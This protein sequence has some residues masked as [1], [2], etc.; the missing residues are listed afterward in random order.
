MPSTAMSN[1]MTF[2][3]V[4]VSLSE[5]AAQRLKRTREWLARSNADVL[6]VSAPENVLYVSGYESMPAM[7]SRSHPFAVI[8]TADRLML[9]APSA[10]FA[11]AIDSGLS[12]DDVV[13]FGRFFFSG[14]TRS[15]TLDVTHAGFDAALKDALGRLRGTK[16]LVDWHA[17]SD[18]A[19]AVVEAWSAG[20]ED[21]GQWML[22]LRAEKLPIEHTLLKHVA[23][24]TERALDAGI[25]AAAV[26]V[27]DKEVSNVVAAAMSAAGG[28][29]RNVTVAGGSASAL[30]DV[31][32]AE[33][34]LQ[35]GDLLRF[36]IGCSYYGY[37]SDIAR[38]AVMG[39]P[40]GLQ[41]SRYDALLAGLETAFEMARTGAV[42]R[43]VFDA[44]V[45]TVE[46][47]GLS[48]YRRQH[49]GHAIGLSVYEWPVITP[50]STAVLRENATFCLETP[51][52]EP[53]WGGMMVEDTGF[54]TREGFK[55]FTTLDR[56]LRVIGA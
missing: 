40:T 35:K 42:A 6:I 36:D 25:A 32:S 10:D 52:Y 1:A 8:L 56:S 50:E 47:K 31:L 43:D 34:P 51:Y 2:I 29:P 17:I 27:T 14:Q 9:V 18:K 44:S 13:P 5:L 12:P 20:V 19:R 37:K 16:A 7:L 4:P 39:E 11:P 24:M 54:I 53:G 45:E 3:P 22:D 15:S 38:T 26:G 28:Y 41:Q 55:S 33:R 48:P 49:V 30:A 21:A 46:K 23:N